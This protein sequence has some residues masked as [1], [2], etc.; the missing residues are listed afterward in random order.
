MT[1]GL[2]DWVLLVFASIGAASVLTAIGVA[3]WMWVADRRTRT[4]TTT[5]DGLR[6]VVLTPPRGGYPPLP[7]PLPPPPRPP[8]AH[9]VSR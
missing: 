1:R 6:G 3:G 9:E 7:R 8:R 4:S 2:L 5:L